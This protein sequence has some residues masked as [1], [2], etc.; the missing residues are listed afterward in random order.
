VQY[1]FT[2]SFDQTRTRRI[3][4]R[5]RRVNPPAHLRQDPGLT[6][7]THH[8]DI[9]RRSDVVMRLEVVERIHLEI[10]DEAI[11]YGRD[12]NNRTLGT[13]APRRQGDNFR[14]LS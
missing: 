2:A 14:M 5:P 11:F 13:R 12:G 4:L 1:C 10:L 3:V 8:R 9:L 7:F 6:D